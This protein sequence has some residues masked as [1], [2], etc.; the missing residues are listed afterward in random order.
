MIIALGSMLGTLQAY[1]TGIYWRGD[2]GGNAQ[3]WPVRGDHV[4]GEHGLEAAWMG[5]PRD[6]ARWVKE[7]QGTF[8][9]RPRGQGRWLWS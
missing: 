1:E 9:A 7:C 8:L 6:H 4:L 5:L 2:D 3:A